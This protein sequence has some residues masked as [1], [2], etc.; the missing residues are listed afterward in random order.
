MTRLWAY[1]PGGTT[2][3]ALYESV[4][5]S[6]L[7]APTFTLVGCGELDEWRGIRNQIRSG[8]RVVYEGAV[9]RSPTFNPIPHE[10]IG[11]IKE[12]CWFLAIKPEM[13]TPGAISGVQKWGVFE[14]ER[15]LSSLH[16]RDA[17]MHGAMAIGLHQVRSDERF[18]RIRTDLIPTPGRGYNNDEGALVTNPKTSGQGRRHR[19]HA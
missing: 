4:D 10:V 19:R 13:K 9:G 7:I 2:G 15:G 5:G 18:M 11:V 16:A 3:F 8:D 17:I 6:A 1:D 12:L 14:W